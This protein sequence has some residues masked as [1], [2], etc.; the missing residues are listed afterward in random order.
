VHVEE[1][2]RLAGHNRLPGLASATREASSRARRNAL[3][4]ATAALEAGHKLIEAKALVRH[5]EWSAWLRTHR[6]L[7]ERTAQRYMRLARQGLKPATV[8][9]LGIAA[10]DAHSLRRDLRALLRRHATGPAFDELVDGFAP[11]ERSR[12]LIQIAH[13]RDVGEMAR[14]LVLA[15]AGFIEADP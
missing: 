3:A 13:A 4:A 10:A 7:S 14:L 1:A 12:F 2:G 15:E 9:V 5:G 6:G 11:A 8:A